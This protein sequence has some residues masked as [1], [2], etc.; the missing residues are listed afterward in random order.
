M[1]QLEFQSETINVTGCCKQEEPDKKYKVIKK[2]GRYRCVKYEKYNKHIIEISPWVMQL[3]DSIIKNTIMHELIHCFPFCCNHGEHFK[4]YAKIINKAY[5]Y[6]I[7]RLGN[8][9]KDYELS[10]LQYEK[11]SYKYTIKC[12]K[13]GKQFH[14]NRLARNFFSKYRC[15]CGG[16][17]EQI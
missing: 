16:K 13:C 1:F 5:G 8:K 9:E 3:D 12:T 7:S 15:L 2:I 4:K 17:L 14:R 11:P 6:D 10:N